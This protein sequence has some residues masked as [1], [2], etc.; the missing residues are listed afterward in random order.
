MDGRR[1]KNQLEMAFMEERRS[2]AP[3]ISKEGTEP[4]IALRQDESPTRTDELMEEVCERENL[5]RALKRV[6][7]NKGSPG[8]DGMKVEELPGYLKERWPAI[9]EE[10]LAGTYKPQAVKRVEIPKPGG[11]VRKLGIPTALDRFIQQA[12]CRCCRADGTGRSPSTA[13]DLD[14][15]EARIKR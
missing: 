4:A 13:T 15:D 9:R 10:L 12:G 1:Q 8:I 6:K 3:T 7:E 14:P 11:G 5:K 2:E